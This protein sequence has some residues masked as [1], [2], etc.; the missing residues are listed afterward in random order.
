MTYTFTDEEMTRLR[1]AMDRAPSIFGQHPWKL[2]LAT[3]EQG[4]T[5]R[6]RV[7]LYSAPDNEDLG[8]LLP[9]EVVISCGAALYNLRLAIQVAGREPSVWLL[10]GLDLDSGLLTTVASQET[11]LASVEVMPGRAAPPTDA[12]QELYEA[13]WLR[14]TDRGPHQYVPVPP[15]ILVEMEIAAARERCWLRALPDHQR[16]QALRAIAA[17]NKKIAEENGLAELLADPASKLLPGPTDERSRV[18]FGPTPEGR[19]GAKAPPTRPIFW[20]NERKP[21]EDRL[22]TPPIARR[23]TQLMALSTDDDRPLDWLRAGE[24]LQHALLNGTRFS[25]S[26]TGGRSTPYRQQLYYA[27]LDPHRLWRRPPAP[28]GFAVEASFLTQSLELA[29]L[30][31]VAPATLAGLGLAGEIADLRESQPRKD[32]WRWPW[33]SYYTEIPQIVLRVGYAP[34]QRVA[35][36]GDSDAQTRPLPRVKHNALYANSVPRHEYDD[37]QYPLPQ[38]HPADDEL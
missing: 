23:R 3:D 22:R 7:E 27:P 4:R 14:R 5:V 1:N 36:R 33:H 17:A 2:E 8:K 24:A 15:P 31:D 35:A 13:L 25:M 6:D 11:L 16:R 20:Q 30:R 29:S 19:R 38:P 26:T 10:P 18:H 12:E 9:R 37:D 34:V 32:R 28:A 21:F